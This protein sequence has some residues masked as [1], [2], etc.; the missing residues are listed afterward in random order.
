M[1]TFEEHNQDLNNCVDEGIVMGVN[2]L[3]LLSAIITKGLVAI[4]QILIEIRDK[5]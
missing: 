1:K 4:T 3:Q 2:D 5:K